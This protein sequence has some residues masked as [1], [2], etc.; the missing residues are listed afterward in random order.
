[1]V[2]GGFSTL[3][4]GPLP[5]HVS[6]VDNNLFFSN[7]PN[8]GITPVGWETVLTNNGVTPFTLRVCATCTK[9]R[10]KKANNSCQP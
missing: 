5:D 4:N 10:C 1:M 3:T 8:K 2:T 7:V 9:G 6:I